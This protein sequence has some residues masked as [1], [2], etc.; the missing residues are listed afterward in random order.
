M[1][2]DFVRDDLGY[3]KSNFLYKHGGENQPV[4]LPYGVGGCQRFLLYSAHLPDILY[5]LSP[6]LPLP[7]LTIVDLSEDKGL[8]ETLEL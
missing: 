4:Y 3:T 1:R 5:S 2:F 7:S 8:Q 6:I